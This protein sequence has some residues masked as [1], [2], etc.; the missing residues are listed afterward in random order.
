MIN[1]EITDKIISYTEKFQALIIGIV[2]T[3]GLIMTAHVIVGA[4]P[5]DGITVTGSASKIVQSDT[6]EL[7]I[8][9]MSKGNT[10]KA[11]LNTIKS[12]T[13]TVV[14]YLKTNGIE[15]KD[16]EIK[17]INGYNTFKVLPNG[18]TSNEVA[19]Y[20]MDQPISIKSN[21]IQKIKKI[22]VDISNLMDK[23]IDIDVKEPEYYYSKISDLK[24]ELLNEATKDAK[25]GASAMLKAT[26]NRTGK[27]QS[28]KMGVFQITSANST[29]V[30]DGGIYDTSSI[31][32]KVTAVANVVFKI[33]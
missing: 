24:V 9:I 20:N 3:L 7:D 25:Q 21:D 28:V 2:V 16:I 10:K 1:K 19:Y 6:A 31:E 17:A 14:A 11:A 27:I 5:S 12:Q 18:N 23:G 32:K 26:H 4:L 29:D 13:P 15:D 8:D 22:S 30:S 33:K